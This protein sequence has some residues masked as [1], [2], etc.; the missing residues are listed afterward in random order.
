MGSALG[1]HPYP[2]IVAEFQS[3]IGKE[4]HA[5]CLRELGVLPNYV[6]A[7]VGGG[8]NAIGIFSAFIKHAEIELIGVEAGGRGTKLGEHAARLLHPQVGVLHGSYSYILQDENGQIAATHS[9]S[10]GLDYPA[11]GPQHAALFAEQRAKY[12]TASDE[13][14][15][16]ALKLLGKTEGILCALESAHA[17]AYVAEVGQRLAKDSVVLVNL[18][19]RGDKDLGTLYDESH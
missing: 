10:A 3:V 2:E 4:A 19:G 1:P 14:A 11:I 16:A 17:L 12:V 18:S 5:Q 7:C 9:I 15:V 13:A 6:V 8:S